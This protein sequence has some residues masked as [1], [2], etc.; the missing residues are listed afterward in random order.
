MK[1]E[2]GI[3]FA[4]FRFGRK[5]KVEKLSTVRDKQIATL[6]VE[7]LVQSGDSIK[8]NKTDKTGIKDSIP[9]RL[10]TSYT[11]LTRALSFPY[12]KLI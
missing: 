12:F 1:C 6:A 3:L 4:I 11:S 7:V 10:E 9:Q 2:T 8:S 5:A